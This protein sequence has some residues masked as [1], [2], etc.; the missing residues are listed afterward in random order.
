MVARVLESVCEE[1]PKY[2]MMDYVDLVCIMTVD[3]GFA[4]QQMIP[5]AIDKIARVRSLFNQAGRKVDIMVDGHVE[6]EMAPKMVAAGANA[7]VMGS[8]GL[9]NH[10]PKD[11]RKTIDFFKNL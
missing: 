8:S 11:Y 5:S 1:L 3:P 7:L 6:T 9:F 2:H 10:E 4:G